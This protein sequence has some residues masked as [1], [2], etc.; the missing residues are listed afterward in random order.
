MSRDAILGIVT[1]AGCAVLYWATLSIETNPLVPVSPAF[2]PRLVVGLTAVFAAV[3]LVNTVLARRGAPARAAPASA[4]APPR[5]GMVVLMFAIFAGYVF[6]LPPLGF[7]VATFAFVTVMQLAL[8]PARGVRR[9]IVVLVVALVATL[10]TYYIFE[11][12]LQVLL[13]RGRWTGF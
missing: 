7:R 8:E 3:L 10:A 6:A 5:Y 4:A 1:L 13:P 12:Y 9:W 2:Y 11:A